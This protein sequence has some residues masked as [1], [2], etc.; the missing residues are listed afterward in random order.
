[1]YLVFLLIVTGFFGFLIIEEILDEGSVEAATLTVG[2]GQTYTT[3]TAAV[4]AAKPGDTIRVYAGTYTENFFINNSLTLK[5]NGSKNTVILGATSGNIIYI[6]SNGVTVTGFKITKG[7]SWAISIYS[8]KNNITLSDLNITKNRYGIYAYRVNDLIITNCQLYDNDYVGINADYCWRVSVTRNNLTKHNDQ[9]QFY[10]LYNSKIENNNFIDGYNGVYDYYSRSL[11]IIG[12][13]F[14]KNNYAIR[15]SNTKGILRD[16]KYINNR[17]GGLRLYRCTETTISNETMT[18]SSTSV[19]LWDFSNV[20]IYNSSLGTGNLILDDYSNLILINT[21]AFANQTNFYD[22]FSRLI[23][24]W[25]LHITVKSIGGVGVPNANVIITNGTGGE[26]ID[27]KTDN[28]GHIKWIRFTEYVENQSGEL[29]NNNPINITAYNKTMIGWLKPELSIVQSQTL[30]ITLS[31]LIPNIDYIIIE[32]PTSKR[33]NNGIYYAGIPK[34]FFAYGYNFT[35]G[36]IKKVD[37]TWSSNDTSKATVIAGPRSATTFDP[38]YIGYCRINASFGSIPD[39]TASI[40]IK[41]LVYNINKNKYYGTIQQGVDNANVGNTI[42]LAKWNFREII[43]INNSL[44]I[45]GQGIKKSV[46]EGNRP[47][48][49]FSINANWVTLLNLKVANGFSWGISIYSDRNN[50]T[51]NSLN[52]TNNRY[53]IYAYRVDDLTIK[54]CQLVDNSYS[55]INVDYCWRVS[56]IGNN[57]TDHNEQIQCYRLYNSKIEG[58]NITDGYTGFYDYYSKSLEIVGNKFIDNNYAI[59]LS[60]TKGLLKDNIYLNNRYEGL[61][62]YSCTECEI[63]NETVIGSR[64]SVSTRDYSKVTIFNSSLDTGNFNLDDFSNLILVNTTFSS[65]QTYFYDDYSKLSV[66]WYL[67][68]NV[69]SKSGV[70]VPNANVVIR[71]VTGA[72]INDMVTN[73][74][75]KIQWLRVVQYFRSNTQ[76]ITHTPHNITA[77]NKTMIGW[78]NPKP[79]ITQSQHITIKLDRPL[80]KLDSIV[81]E[82][83]TGQSIDGRTYYT[84]VPVELFAMAH[85]KTVGAIKKVDVTW[86]SNATGVGKVTAGPAMITTLVPVAPGIC[87]ISASNGTLPKANAKVTVVGLVYN[88][89]KKE[90]YGKIQDALDQAN[91]GNTIMLLRRKFTENFMINKSIILTGRGM[92]KSIVYSSGPGN[93]VTINSNW[94]SLS[95]FELRDG[96]SWGIAINS[97][98]NNIT[99]SNLSITKNRYGI[100]AYRVDDLKISNCEILDNDYSG[101]NVDYCWRVSITRNNL[102]GHNEHIQCYRLYNSKIERN[103]LTNGYNCIYDYYSKSLTVIGNRFISNYYG[104]RLS[105]TKGLIKNNTLKNNRYEGMVFYNC[106]ETNIENITITGSYNPVRVY[107][108]S[109][110]TIFNSSLGTGDFVINDYSALTLVNTTYSCNKTNFYDDFST[111]TVKWYLKVKVVTNGNIPISGA[112]ITVTDSFDKMIYNQTSNASG[113]CDLI[114]CTHFIQNNT[115]KTFHTPHNVTCVSPLGTGYA[116]PEPIMQS[117]KTVKVI[118]VDRISPIAKAGPD[119]IVVQHTNVT[120]NGTGCSD[121]VGI[122][123]WTWSFVYDQKNTELYDSKPYFI[124]HIAGKYNVSLEITDGVNWASDYMMVTVNDITPPIANAGED[125]Y[126]N[127]EETA[128]FNGTCCT[129]NVGISKLVWTFEYDNQDRELK[130]YKPEFIFDIVGEYNVTLNVTDYRGNWGVDVVTVFVADI[131]NPI[132]NAGADLIVNQHEVVTFDGSNCSDNVGI[133]N[134]TWTFEYDFIPVN[135]YGLAPTFIFHTPGIYNVT[136]KVTDAN[137]NWAEDNITITVLDISF[138][139]AI[140][141]SD[142]TIDQHRK[143][144]FYGGESSDNL[145]IINWTWSFEYDNLQINLYGS[146]PSF[147]FDSAG[148][149]NITLTVYDKAGNYASDVITVIVY[150]ITD[151]VAVAGNNVTIYQNETV[152]F[153]GTNSWDNVG[154]MNWSWLIQLESQKSMIYG[155]KPAWTFLEVGNYSVELIVKDAESNQN[156]DSIWI[157]VLPLTD[158]PGDEPTKPS[159][160]DEPDKEVGQIVMM[161]SILVIILV[162][163]IITLFLFMFKRKTKRSPEGPEAVLEE[164]EGDKIESPATTFPVTTTPGAQ[165]SSDMSTQVQPTMQQPQAQVFGQPLGQTLPQLPPP[166]PIG[167]PTTTQPLLPAPVIAPPAQAPAQVQTTYP[168]PETG[169][170]ET[171]PDVSQIPSPDATVE[172]YP[173]TDIMPE[174]EQAPITEPGVEPAPS[175]EP[176][177][178]SENQTPTF[179]A[180]PPIEPESETTDVPPTSTAPLPQPPIIPPAV[181]SFSNCPKCGSMLNMFPDGSL[182]CFVCG[183]TGK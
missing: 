98:Y 116:N 145:G 115:V 92:D 146:E 144:T 113:I 103:N 71:N 91:I 123:N 66:Q 20:V 151:P 70:G 126:I 28:S 58:N 2:K 85:N 122:R 74:Q 60:R 119:Q 97:G 175:T 76:N 27:A 173:E 140:A 83:S 50:I 169:I 90:Y 150:D 108:F 38:I 86:S 7:N 10:R 56:I 29:R 163:I 3:I 47:G 11:N 154:I 106:F 45:S 142:V 17:Y 8:D 18:G 128:M 148:V 44:T 32:E 135:L 46:I 139:I 6:N 99:I 102:T 136:L 143:V 147:V 31:R 39:G 34:T 73:A 9:T 109:D 72:V 162:I 16:N 124:F 134:W 48:S 111:L 121:N 53:G 75:G 110:V 4:N 127:Q 14:I 179:S 64:T 132:A 166:P 177:D 118:I 94:V 96:F 62:F 22:E 152:Y 133:A 167:V 13:K 65:N 172:T 157:N 54:N 68:I 51:L 120:F 176:L 36:K 37:A 57:L 42:Q 183:F 129:D 59:R 15:L 130:G 117:S 24:K 131:T 95:D 153:D 30:Q 181:P 78:A 12:N 93:I 49:V 155:P 55:G 1:V 171:P 81:I 33:V 137:D 88:K 104:I 105:R 114:V 52:I 180:E 149:Y 182:L 170:Q 164:P 82:D 138:P 35:F 100:Y 67:H 112:L 80:P 159:E 174:S 89:N 43:S 23:V 26:L 165:I 61:V 158:T 161:F 19:S 125:I 79:K 101:I 77:Y 41:G 21:T 107:D 178:E 40:T 63:R 69:K 160:G 84:G 25:Y 156:S 168:Q 5:G 141:G 87:K